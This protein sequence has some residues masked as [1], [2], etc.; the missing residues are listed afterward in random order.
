MLWVTRNHVHVDRVVS[1]WLIKRFIDLD[2]KFKFVQWPGTEL[3]PEDGTPFDFP[4]MDIPFTHHDGKCTFEVLIDHYNLDDPVLK[5]MAEIIHGADVSKDID[6]APEARGVELVSSGLA[7][8]SD[9]DHQ[10]LKRGFI[11]FDSMYAGLL[12]RRLRKEMKDQLEGLGRLEK[13]KL[14]FDELRRRLPESFAVG[15]HD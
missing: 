11:L 4:N 6:K 12:L 14:L 5:D 2:A 7:Y 8:I 10:A 3:T 9:D 1:P 15:K 13:F